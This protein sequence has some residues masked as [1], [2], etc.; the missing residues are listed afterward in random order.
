MAKFPLKKLYLS[1]VATLGAG[2]L[3]LAYLF[4][5]NPLDQPITYLLPALSVYFVHRK[6]VSILRGALFLVGTFFLSKFLIPE[7]LLLY[8]IGFSLL[9]GK[10]IYYE[11]VRFWK[12]LVCSLLFYVAIHI[13]ST[14]QQIDF[15]TGLIPMQLSHVI[16]AAI[17]SFCI[18]CSLL[19]YY[20]VKD[21]VLSAFESYPWLEPSEPARMAIQAKQLYESVKSELRQKQFD[22]N[23]L[24]ELEEFSEKMIHLC[25][26]LQ[27]M[28][29]TLSSIDIESLEDQIASLR[30]KVEKTIDVSSK[31]N[32]EKALLNREK[33]R[34]QCEALQIQAERV[35]A[36]ILN[37]VSA[38]EN[39]RFAYTHRSFSSS[40]H[41][42]E[43]IEF[44]LQMAKNH[45]ENV[46]ETSEA[47]Q[48]L[49]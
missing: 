30:E 13:T 45:A 9:V 23:A 8:S 17:F 16:H 14:W 10:L 12:W 46:Y 19:P 15:M 41:E 33:Q 29:M 44:L 18:A 21:A 25:H 22:Q 1:L 4:Y 28:N 31:R 35:H 39:V 26:Q 42:T 6:D 48:K 36:Q 32:Y 24:K 47:Y 5:L 2:F 3:L 37:Y 7:Y 49:V 43:G 27:E 38:L 11:S 20:L 40:E 34:K